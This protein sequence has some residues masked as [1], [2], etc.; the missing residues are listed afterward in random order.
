MLV[1]LFCL[2]A[3]DNNFIANWNVPANWRY[4]VDFS[5]YWKTLVVYVYKY[6]LFSY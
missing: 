5:V 6:I 1:E 2:N 4:T 3:T